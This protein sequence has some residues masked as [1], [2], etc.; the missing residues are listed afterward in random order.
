MPQAPLPSPTPKPGKAP[1]MSALESGLNGR[2]AARHLH[3]QP[4]RNPMSSTLFHRPRRAGP[5]MAM[6]LALTPAT[7]LS[8]TFAL[9]AQATPISYHVQV[10]P[11]GRTYSAFNDLGQAVS[12]TELYD[13]RN[14]SFTQLVSAPEGWQI[15]LTGLNNAGNAYGTMGNGSETLNVLYH[16]GTLSTFARRQVRFTSPVTGISY[17]DF[18][19]PVAINNSGQVALQMSDNF[20]NGSSGGSIDA[21]TGERLFYRAGLVAGFNDAGIMALN[22]GG[23]V[24]LVDAQGQTVDHFTGAGVRA[25]ALNN[26]GMVAGSRGDNGFVYSDGTLTAFRADDQP[27]DAN[28]LPISSALDGSVLVNGINEHG[29]IV[30]TQGALG[31]G[32]GFLYSEGEALFLNEITDLSEGW[33][34]VAAT[35]IN[36]LGQINATACKTQSLGHVWTDCTAVLLQPDALTPSVPEPQSQALVLVGLGALGWVGRRRHR[37]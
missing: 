23:G 15:N 8:L 11:T 5:F 14:G 19:V 32:L 30:G 12:G 9:P 16:A 34:I 7:T 21:S 1:A 17:Y 35:A 28:G 31:A 3:H 22:F 6:T 26:A 24:D 36:E 13:S 18:I 25:T 20:F 2:I 33:N 4:T 10:L 37:R 27:Y 29:Q